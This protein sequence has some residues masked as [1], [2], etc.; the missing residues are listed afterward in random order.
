MR[1]RVIHVAAP[2]RLR[3]E[4]PELYRSPERCNSVEQTLATLPMVQVCRS[5]PLTARIL[6]LFERRWPATTVLA[7]I[8]ALLENPPDSAAAR[9]DRADQAATQ[10]KPPRQQARLDESAGNLPDDRAD[11]VQWHALT[12]GETAQRLHSAADTGLTRDEVRRRLARYGANRL[13]QAPGRSALSILLKQFQ[14]LPV[15]MLAVSAGVAAATGGLVDA[16]AIV[17]VLLINGAIGYVTEQQAERT[18]ALL[19]SHPPGK[20]KVRREDTTVSA[21]AQT[22]VPGDVM[23]LMPGSQVAADARLLETHRL[24]LDESALT[25]ESLPVGKFAGASVSPDAQ[26]GDRRNMVYMGTLVTGGSA[27]AMVVETGADT[28]LGRIQSMVD[29]AHSPETPMERQ[30][31]SLGTRLGI[32]SG[33]VCTGIFAVGLLRGQPW[34]QMLNSA[35]SLAVAAVPEGLPAVATSTLALGIRNMNRHKVLVRRLEA[36]ESLGSIQVLCLDKTGTLTRNRMR[37]VELHQAD[38]FLHVGEQQWTSGDGEPFAPQSDNDLMRLL[39]IA[40]L[41]NEIET[42]ETQ[43]LKGASTELALVEL[44]Q[45]VGI[46][47][48]ALR[49]RLPTIALQQR[50]EDRPLMSTVHR[51][52]DDSRFIAVKGRP[53]EV[54]ARSTHHLVGETP[55][56]LDERTRN[57]ILAANESLAGKALR[58]LGMAYREVRAGEPVE[59]YE[60]VWV[61][62]AGMQDA[63]RPD[64]KPL[65]QRLRAAGM[66]TVMITG[67]Q[68]ATAAAVAREL[69]LNGGHALQIL[70]SSQLAHMDEQLL[71]GLVGQIDVFARVSP[72]NKL[73]I[74]R[75]LQKAGYHVAMTGDG[76]NDSPALKAADVSVAMGAGGTDA[77]R[78]VADVV[79]EDDN[80]H[81]LVTGVSQGR[82]IYANIRRSVHYLLSTNF[83]EIEVMAAAVALGLGPPL[84]P[85]Q[86]LWINLATDVFPGL[87]LSLEPPAADIMERPPRPAGEPIVSRDK[88]AHMALESGYISA[89]SLAAYA[90]GRFSGGPAKGSTLLF[91]TLTSAQLLHAISCRSGT[92]GVFNPEGRPRNRWL[93]AA[94]GGTALLQALTLL[95]PMRRLLKTVPL[96]PADIGLS[97]A[98]ACVPLAINEAAK[99]ARHNPLGQT[100]DK[101]PNVEEVAL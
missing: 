45:A 93:D 29:T 92:Q 74:V 68:S 95:P 60:L 47:L 67:D 56:P 17:G 1:I 46:D 50:A 94:L 6:V 87:A 5:N 9:S 84:N 2:G 62:L 13:E 59:A 71:A 42:D 98:A 77:A 86:L 11:E 82:T 76:I 96:G 64:M 25:G 99:L 101:T 97:L 58:V 88:L 78:S 31:D 79:I 27:T 39:T 28:Q 53:S 24:T 69:G 85:M 35:M 32:L 100:T 66:R 54:L 21:D 12:P 70:D 83:S 72:A 81:T 40:A 43:S 37:V 73:Q 63:L 3:L 57:S 55:V 23:L 36:V 22:L 61:G 44:A 15:A 10:Q 16:A 80:L 4:I 34:L 18:I 41:C 14:S 33:A 26:L 8:E 38:R 51:A 65:L 52:D 20:L 89:A 48:R 30:L 75:A 19:G 7:R 91:Q 49:A 90:W